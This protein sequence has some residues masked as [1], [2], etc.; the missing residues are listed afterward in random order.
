M[1]F[2]LLH[3]C[4]AR[5]ILPGYYSMLPTWHMLCFR[6]TAKLCSSLAKRCMEVKFDLSHAELRDSQSAAGAPGI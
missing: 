3:S 4:R 2:P 5:Q 6:A 1:P